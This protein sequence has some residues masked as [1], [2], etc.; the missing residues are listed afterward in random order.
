M[1]AIR[2][3]FAPYFKVSRLASYLPALERTLQAFN[4]RLDVHIS[5]QDGVF[6][7]VKSLLSNYASDSA[8]ITLLGKS[9]N[10]LTSTVDPP[11]YRPSEYAA[12]LLDT[13]SFQPWRMLFH[14]YP[15]TSRLYNWIIELFT[16]SLEFTHIYLL[17]AWHAFASIGQ[18]YRRVVREEKL[19]TET[20][21]VAN[22]LDGFTRVC[23]NQQSSLFDKLAGTFTMF[24]HLTTL[25]GACKYGPRKGVHYALKWNVH[26]GA[27]MF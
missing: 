14:A 13:Y 17:Y 4:R 15:L 23:I 18:A 2:K 22:F 1:P 6:P 5:S 19:E 12:R 7:N 27:E 25:I 8:G 16:I 26:L 24:S 10:S 11:L 20:S 3:Q 9:F 21:Q